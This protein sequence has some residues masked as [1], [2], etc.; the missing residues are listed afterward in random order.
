MKRDFLLFAGI[1]VI[2]IFIVFPE[3]AF[4]ELEKLEDTELSAVDAQAFLPTNSD[5]E[6]NNFESVGETDLLN[7]YK[8]PKALNASAPNNEVSGFSKS[9]YPSSN[10]FDSNTPSPNQFGGGGMLP[11]HSCCF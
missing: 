8:D 4:C 9:I 3:S 2:S 10:F 11:D 5:Q 7:N 6:K 1:F